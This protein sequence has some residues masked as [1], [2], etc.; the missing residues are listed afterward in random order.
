MLN[1][2]LLTY[3]TRRM[4]P[5]VTVLLL[6]FF[7]PVSL[8]LVIDQYLKV[9]SYGIVGLLIILRWKRVLYV[10]TADK[11]LL[12]LVGLCVASILWSA[13]PSFTIDEVKALLRSTMLGAYLAARYSIEEQMQLWAWVLG[14]AAFLSII[15]EFKSINT[16]WSG[17]FTYK[18]FLGQAMTFAAV[19]FLTMS[20]KQGRKRWLALGG[21]MI[22]AMLVF[23]SQSKSAYLVFGVLILVFPLYK[24]V[25]QHY[26]LRVFL[27]VVSILLGSCAIALALGNLEIILV[28]VLGKNL[29][30]S[31]RTTVWALIF[32]KI[33]ERPWL[34]YGYSG[35]WTSDNALYVLNNTWAL[36]GGGDRAGLRFNA[37]NSFIE[38]LLQ[39][40]VFGLLVYM[41]DFLMVFIRS[42]RLFSL[43]KTSTQKICIFWVFQALATIFL[44][45]WSDSSG[46]LGAGSMWSFYVSIVLSIAMLD[47]RIRREQ[48][49]VA[50][51]GQTKS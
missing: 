45:N 26:K 35:F 18:N 25:R 34:G 47:R 13:S 44:F 14:I 27:F 4:E 30:L 3:S 12:V 39:L 2:Q 38:V 43:E 8:P 7:L 16:P 50:V 1:I 36:T 29:T 10:S 32:D 33:S 15:L 49:L 24:L 28:N 41:L 51:S 21:F 23:L 37:H 42:V 9:A 22:A 17:L 6:L 48:R 11:L 19:L 46:V 5:V 20:L 40:G 31:G